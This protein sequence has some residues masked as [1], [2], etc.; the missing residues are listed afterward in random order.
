M[1][2]KETQRRYDKGTDLGER[3]GEGMA[4]GDSGDSRS[5]HLNHVFAMVRIDVIYM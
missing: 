2:G 3:R 1:K 4:Q 5:L